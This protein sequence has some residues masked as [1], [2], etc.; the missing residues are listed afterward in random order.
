MQPEIINKLHAALYSVS[1]LASDRER[2]ISEM[3]EVI[4]LETLEKVLL[5]L[6]EDKRA[7]VVAFLNDDDLDGAV[8]IMEES[9]VDV[10]AIITEVATSVMDDVVGEEKG[11]GE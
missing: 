8:A 7:Q 9:D 10:D 1:P 6:P 4:W 11:E 5:S 2:I 3:G